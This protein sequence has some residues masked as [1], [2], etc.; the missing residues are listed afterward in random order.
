M[1]KLGLSS[2]RVNMIKSEE[3]VKIGEFVVTPFAVQ[4]DAME[5]L[6]FLIHHTEC[7][8][9][10]FLT[11]SYYSS[12]NFPD[13]NQ[14]IIEANYCEDILEE[15]HSSGRIHKIV[16]D[17]VRRSHMSIQTLK[18]MLKENDLSKVNNVVLIHLSEGNSD[19]RRFKK[20]VEE[21][22]GKTVIIAEKGLTIEFNKVSF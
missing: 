11:D 5:P 14:I 9:V 3:Q 17:R 22:T 4:H 8:Q 20:E 16:R 6:G 18:T 12:F 10:L 13:L 15:Q 19:S 1:E 7:G 2:Y 21:L